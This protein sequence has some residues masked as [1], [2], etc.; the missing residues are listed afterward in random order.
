MSFLNSVLSTINKDGSGQPSRPTAPIVKAKP[1][2]QPSNLTAT[3]KIESSGTLKRKAEQETGSS[4]LKVPKTT[5]V[6]SSISTPSRSN[7]TSPAARSG[8]GL[9]KP[10][11]PYKGTSRPTVSTNGAQIKPSVKPVTA[12]KPAT[13]TTPASTSSA[14]APAKKGYLATLERAR[15][16]QEANKGKAPGTIKHIKVEKK[17]LSRREKERLAAEAKA[18]QKD[19]KLREKLQ[20]TGRSRDGTPQTTNGKAVDPKKKVETGYKGTM[21]PAAPAAAPAYKGTMRPVGSGKPAAPANKLRPGE[22]SRY[23]YVEDYSD[24]EEEDEEDDY[25]SASSDMEAGMDDIDR[26]ELMSARV[27]R[28]EDEEAL[29]E[30]EELKRQKLERKR[31]LQALSAAA[32][33]KKKVF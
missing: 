30:E 25:D 29:K 10:S 17:H 2:Q 4:S 22:S 1:P 16:A 19:P 23:R 27:A 6:A 18:A 3:A 11:E 32:A 9:A 14:P 20:P 24:E 28:K 21:R 15:M 8:G 31:K 7:T 13:S 5:S 33:K 26:E 12:T